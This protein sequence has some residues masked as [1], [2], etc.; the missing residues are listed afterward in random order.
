MRQTLAMAQQV[1][2]Q[3]PCEVEVH[4]TG[5]DVA[6]LAGRFGQQLRFVEQLG[7]DL[8]ERLQRA[9]AAA[10]AAT[11]QRVVVIGTDC[12][13]LE[14]DLVDQAFA[15]LARADVVLGP[16]V[17]GGYYL[18]GLNAPR[19]ALFQ[20]IDWGTDRVL[21]QTLQQA[22]RLGCRV[23]QLR[24]LADVDHPEDLLAC[25]RMA[26]AFADVLPAPRPGWLSIIVPTLNEESTIAQTLGPLTGLPRV[27]VIVADG[28]SSDAT[29]GIA[30]ERG[31]A[32]VP[33]RPGRGRQMNAGAALA[34]GELLL[35]LHADSRLPDGF[36]DYVWSTLGE[37]VV[38][39][40]FRL[41]I[42]DRRTGL[43]WIEWGANLRSRW[44][45]LPYGDQ[46]LFVRA[47]DFYVLGGF[48]CWPLMEDYELCRRLRRRGQ[49]RLAPAS[50]VTSARRWRRLGLVRTT[51]LNQ[52]CVLGYWLGV[53]PERLAGWYRR[54]GATN[55]S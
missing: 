4:F 3:R 44:R 21:P 2:A 42:D 52:L 25:R 36:Q 24:P 26:A 27:E 33:S 45:Q 51:L 31:A 34:Q 13:T 46:G 54:P 41:R 6:R 39:G 23:E 48:P 8:G 16:A 30:R 47:R 20:S 40:A 19:P 10:F 22:R 29:V 9:V 12:P 37:G 55:R 14:A 50:V 1:R 15:A 32:V 43:R 5:G 53:S 49:I 28:G 35:F 7:A 17:D 38:A 11:A 18:V